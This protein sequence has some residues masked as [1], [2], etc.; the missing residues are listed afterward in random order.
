LGWTIASGFLLAVNIRL[1]VDEDGILVF[2]GGSLPYW[3]GRW[4]ALLHLNGISL[5]GL[6]RVY[7]VAT[8]VV[9]G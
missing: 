9:P 2:T 1:G 6:A 4:E 7:E 5:L 8:G 3:K